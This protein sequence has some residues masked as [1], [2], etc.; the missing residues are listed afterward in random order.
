MNQIVSSAPAASPRRGRR[1]LAIAALLLA[2]ALLVGPSLLSAVAG[3]RADAPVGIPAGPIYTIW[4]TVVDSATG[5]PPAG[6]KIRVYH[7]DALTGEFF[8][9]DGPDGPFITP[10]ADGVWAADC[11]ELIDGW[12]VV[13]LFYEPG[14]QSLEITGPTGSI[15]NISEARVDLPVTP[16]PRGADGAKPL[17]GTL[18]EFRFTLT[19]PGEPTATPTPEE[20]IPS[21]TFTPTPEETIP[22]PVPTIPTVG[23]S[24]TRINSQRLPLVFRNFVIE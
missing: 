6:A 16:P 7:K 21:P 1:G 23:P 13:K 3:P 12:L 5:L 9:I 19:G 8:G 10:G 14:W 2:V 4:G 11:Y 22:S 17:L 20:T 18:G 24:P 15:I